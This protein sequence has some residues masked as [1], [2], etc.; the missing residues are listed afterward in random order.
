MKVILS[1]IILISV[2]IFVYLILSTKEQNQNDNT[3]NVRGDMKNRPRVDCNQNVTYCF[4]D[5]NCANLCQN[6]TGSRCRNGICINT[7]VINSQ[8]PLNECDA[9]RGVVTF[10]SGNT[11]LGRFDF[12]CRSIDLG[13]ASDDINVTNRMCIGGSINIDY[14]K[15][16]PDIRDCSCPP[17]TRSVILPSTSQVRSYVHCL[18]LNVADR[19]VT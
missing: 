16:F 18:P 15:Q 5:A 1:I 10:L 19:I 7:N 9:R 2:I 8:L 6:S 14:T 17:D 13:I 12:L 4:E 3:L 11:A